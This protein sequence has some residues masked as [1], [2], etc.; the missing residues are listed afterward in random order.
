[1]VRQLK[2]LGFAVHD[3]PDLKGLRDAA[4]RQGVELGLGASVV[5]LLNVLDRCDKPKSLLREAA[6]LLRPGGHLLL[7]VV[8]PFRPFVEVGSQ[9]RP[10]SEA[11]GL[12]R[13]ASFEKSA[14]LLWKALF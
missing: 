1:M 5:S 10:P 11:L 12:P 8:L 14:E 2:K 4:Q 6:S 3:G 9:R 7:A 13:D